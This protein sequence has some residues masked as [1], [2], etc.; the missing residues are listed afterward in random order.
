MFI[1][2][3]N[4]F[5]VLVTHVTTLAD[6]WTGLTSLAPQIYFTFN[7]LTAGPVTMSLQNGAIHGPGI[8]FVSHKH[9]NPRVTY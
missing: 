9:L 6:T 1:F 4:P 7:S 2:I 5:V 8:G 3:S